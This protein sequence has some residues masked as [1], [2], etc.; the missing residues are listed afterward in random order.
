MPDADDYRA[1]FAR[2]CADEGIIFVDMTDDFVSLYEEQHILA[3]GFVNTGVGVGHL[4][5]YGH[6]MIAK[7]L[8][9]IIEG[10]T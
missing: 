1:C 10:G 3:H 8:A 2:M 5:R 6:E 9:Q 4:N 7:R